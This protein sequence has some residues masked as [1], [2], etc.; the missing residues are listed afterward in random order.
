MRTHA[1]RCNVMMRR[2]APAVAT[3]TAAAAVAMG[4][5]RLWCGVQVAMQ[6]HYEHHA[7]DPWVAG[8]TMDKAEIATDKMVDNGAVFR[9]ALSSAVGSLYARHEIS[10]EHPEDAT[11]RRREFPNFSGE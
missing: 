4:A 5:V 3:T 6:L 8:R 11:K 7:A 1:T 2:H 10:E 9:A